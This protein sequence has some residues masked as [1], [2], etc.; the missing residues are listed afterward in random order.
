VSAQTFAS[1]LHDTNGLRYHELLQEQMRTSD[2]PDRQVAALLFR[3]TGE[4]LGSAA[5]GFVTPP[6]EK[7]NFRSDRKSGQKYF[8]IEHAERRAIFN[9]LKTGAK[10][11]GATIVV[12]LFPCADCA[13]AIVQSGIKTVVAPKIASTES[14]HLETM[15]AAR[16]IFKASE[17][18]VFELPPIEQLQY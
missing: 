2:D 18:E 14:R 3:E 9:S 17:I 8:W 11:E 16:D 13:R 15:A 7:D 12:S 4:F 1:E 10:L 6:S 5:N